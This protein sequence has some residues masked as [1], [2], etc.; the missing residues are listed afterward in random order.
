MS[1][2]AP[3]TSPPMPA[4]GREARASL[5]A[6][7]AR[8]EPLAIDGLP[9][10]LAS[11]G[12][13]QVHV[14]YALASPA[15]D[16]LFWQTAVAALRGPV[17]VLSTR[18]PEN[19]AL[20]LREHGIDVAKPGAT[21]AW[22]NVCTL[23]PL[24]DRD[25]ADVLIEALDALADQ[26]AA[27]GSQFLIEGA[28][29]FFA[30]G[31]ASLLARQGEKLAGWCAQRRY[32]VLIVA[33]PP[34]LADDREHAEL[35][36]FQ[37]R[38]AGAAQLLQ[39]QGQYHWEVAFWRAGD[40]VHGSQSLPLRFSA[41]Q[42]RLTVSGGTFDQSTVEAGLL[43]PD[44]DRVIVSQD[45]VLNERVLPPAWEIVND[46]EA[47]V[48]AARRAVAATV[49]LAFNRRSS[50]DTLAE[51]VH[52]LRLQCGEALK[53]I[54]REEAVALRYESVILN[55]GANRVI[56]GERPLSQVEAIVESLQGQVYLRPIP[57]DYRASIAAV[58]HGD[59]TGYVSAAHFVELVHAAVE[60]S[61]VIQLPNVLI[62]LAALPDVAHVDALKACR[63]TRAGDIV[64]ASGDSLYVFFFACRLADA[65]AVCRRVFD[66]PLGELFQGEQRCGDAQSILALLDALTREIER[67]MPPDYSGWLAHQ[68][69]A[70]PPRAPAASP[71]EAQ[72]AGVAPP[73]AEGGLLPELNAVSAQSGQAATKRRAIPRPVP[74]PLKREDG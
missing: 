7:L 60:R 54:V 26:C 73:A 30:W 22:S 66:V 39:V 40:A 36:V 1:Q 11:L 65:D 59:E 58:T 42:S 74:L 15:R 57:A 23:R 31:D 6:R 46:N 68:Q 29:A 44:E 48:T 9:P 25:G 14:V 10:A 8:R 72:A 43:A 33:S 62:R 17:T 51:Q 12:A 56:H 13:G 38:F 70:A 24:P 27:Q 4:A 34:S 69:A 61:R 55:L 47:A 20:T 53:I 41:A 28:E 5:L 35:A 37:A 19:L 71:D 3:A 52:S 49:I 45:A 21:S 2:P 67:E 16:A 18:E 63:L 32:G 64:T 50:L